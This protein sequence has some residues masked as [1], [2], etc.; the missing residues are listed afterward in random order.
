[1]ESLHPFHFIK[2]L[3]VP[4]AANKWS[5]ILDY[6]LKVSNNEAFQKFNFSTQWVSLSPLFQNYKKCH[7]SKPSCVFDD[8]PHPFRAQNPIFSPDEWMEQR[9]EIFENY[10]F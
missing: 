4:R 2:V 3:F 7:I 1:L 5:K 8:L 10:F 9:I 6:F